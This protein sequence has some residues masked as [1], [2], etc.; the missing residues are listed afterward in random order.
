MGAVDQHRDRAAAYQ[1]EPARPDDAAETATDRAGGE[2]SALVDEPLR[3]R[4][5][6][7]GVLALREAAQRQRNPVFAVAAAPAQVLM[8]VVQGGGVLRLRRACDRRQG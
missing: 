7:G 2:R 1:L 8:G 4:E 5:G 6:D 3:R